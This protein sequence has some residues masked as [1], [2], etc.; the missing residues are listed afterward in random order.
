MINVEVRLSPVAEKTDS[1]FV[2]NVNN[3]DEIIQYINEKVIESPFYPTIVMDI[4]LN[5]LHVFQ[6]VL[7]ESP[8][9]FQITLLTDWGDSHISDIEKPDFLAKVNKVLL[10]VPTIVDETI[11]QRLS[12]LES[13]TQRLRAQYVS[14]LDTH[15]KDILDP[16]EMIKP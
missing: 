3:L 13:E 9:R 4:K 10:Q 2:Y 1:T 14:F 8:S 6:I 11:K 16:K 5:V 15:A 12:N 7:K